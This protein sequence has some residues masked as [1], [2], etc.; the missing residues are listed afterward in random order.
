MR[1]RAILPSAKCQGGGDIRHLKQLVPRFRTAIDKSSLACRVA[2]KVLNVQKK[3]GISLKISLTPSRTKEK[4]EELAMGLKKSM[5]TYSKIMDRTEKSSMGKNWIYKKYFK[6]R[7][8]LW[9]VLLFGTEKL[10][11]V[12]TIFE[13]LN[14]IGSIQTYDVLYSEIT[15]I[16]TLT[17]KEMNNGQP[18][19]NGGME[20]FIAIKNT[21]GN[22]YLAVTRP[23]L[24]QNVTNELRSFAREAKRG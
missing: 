22:L 5:E 2:G 21:Q 8:I 1:L 6:K 12:R 15:E 23:E 13:D 3:R 20:H 10:Y 16:T 14:S 18:F 9:I 24:L 4:E 17:N 7:S 19:E 11:C